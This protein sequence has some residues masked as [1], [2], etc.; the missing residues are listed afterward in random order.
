MPLCLDPDQEST[1]EG[2]VCVYVCVR[3]CVHVFW[4]ADTDSLM[5]VSV[6]V[7]MSV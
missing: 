6:C 5:C 1:P 4:I 7:H 2:D 3:V